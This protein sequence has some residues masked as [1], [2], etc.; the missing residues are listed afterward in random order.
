MGRNYNYLGSTSMAI[1]WYKETTEWSTT[2]PNHTYLL[3]DSK[4]EMFAY[5]MFGK[6]QPITFKAPIKIDGRGRKFK[7][8][9][10]QPNF[11]I[12]VEEEKPKGRIFTVSSSDGKKT[13][14]VSEHLGE[15]SCSCTGFKFHGKCKHIES[16]Q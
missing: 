8:L 1:K 9:D 3:S 2:T 14:T 12:K 10:E 7:L 5:L 6:G 13:Y 11:N 4:S 15:W 16:V